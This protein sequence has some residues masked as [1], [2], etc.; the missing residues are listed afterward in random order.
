MERKNC[1]RRK[2]ERSSGN[3]GSFE[4]RVLGKPAL[5]LNLSPPT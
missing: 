3:H 2:M 5:L 4:H 1:M